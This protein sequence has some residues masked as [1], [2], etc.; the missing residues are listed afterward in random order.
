MIDMVLVKK[1]MLHFLQDVRAVRGMGRGISD[2]HVLLYKLKLMEDM[3][4]KD[5]SSKWS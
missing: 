3:D 4:Y 5:R 1:E 2:Q